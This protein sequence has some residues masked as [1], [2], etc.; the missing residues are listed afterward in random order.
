MNAGSSLDW[1]YSA[2]GWS[3]A[4]IAGTFLLW[5]LF[6]DR[7]RGRRRCPKCWYDMRGSPGLRCPEC[8]C[9]AKSDRE[10]MKTRRRRKL[11]VLAALAG[12]AGLATSSVPA[13]RAGG[14]VALI[15]SSILVFIAPV[16]TSAAAVKLTLTPGPTI[17]GLTGIAINPTLF[18]R[19][20]PTQS[21]AEEAWRRLDSGRLAQWQARVFVNR[22]MREIN[23]SPASCLTVPDRWVRGHDLPVDIRPHDGEFHVSAVTPKDQQAFLMLPARRGTTYRSNVQIQIARGHVR[24]VTSSIPIQIPLA[25]SF[26]NVLMPRPD[27]LTSA[28]VK[29]ALDPYLV[30]GNGARPL[31]VS[32]RADTPEWSVLPFSIAYTFEIRFNEQVIGRGRGLVGWPRTMWKDWNEP[33]IEWT[34]GGLDQAMQP[35]AR[36]TST[37]RGDPESQLRA[38]RIYPFGAGRAQSWTGEFTIPLLIKPHPGLNKGLGQERRF[39]PDKS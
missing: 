4:A 33:D 27:S 35:G 13:Y 26:E 36:L 15:P 32:D 6:W 7:S 5:A 39:S 28:Q 37:F 10:L 38:F 8:G 20:K 12:G 22:R 19:A 29:A 30:T 17:T 24:L 23:F 14:W 18:G 31:I 25:E 16:D 21:L 34:P 1:L 3:L 9:E 2:A 11:A